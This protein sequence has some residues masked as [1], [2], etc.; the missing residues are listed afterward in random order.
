MPLLRLLLFTRCFFLMDSLNTMGNSPTCKV[1]TGI[2]GASRRAGRWKGPRNAFT[3]ST[4]NM[5]AVDAVPTMSSAMIRKGRMS[6]GLLAGGRRLHSENKSSVP[7][8]AS[9]S[10]FQ[11]TA[12]VRTEFVYADRRTRSQILLIGDWTAWEPIE[13]ALE[14]GRFVSSS[15]TP[16]YV[17]LLFR[18][19]IANQC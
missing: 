15:F 16:E 7:F 17:I 1:V 13:M 10:T 3:S 9:K 6:S 18:I 12:L 2:E 19:R 14:K 11:A 5:Y 4:S 8:I